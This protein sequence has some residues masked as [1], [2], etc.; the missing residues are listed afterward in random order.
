MSWL[1]HLMKWFFWFWWTPKP[2]GDRPPGRRSYSRAA[3]KSTN[4]GG[5]IFSQHQYFNDIPSVSFHSSTV[6]ASISLLLS[7]TAERPTTIGEEIDDYGISDS[8]A[9]AHVSGGDDS[10][11]SVCLRQCQVRGDVSSRPSSWCLR[12]MDVLA[13]RCAVTMQDEIFQRI[14]IQDPGRYQ[15]M[16]MSTSRARQPKSE[17]PCGSRLKYAIVVSTEEDIS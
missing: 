12:R 14:W 16:Y 10:Q 9:K 6:F 17:Q 7:L 13:R 1:G 3:L 11:R 2:K 8:R 15:H 4:G 5:D